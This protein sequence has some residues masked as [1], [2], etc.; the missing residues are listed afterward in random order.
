MV[1][2]KQL[3]EAQEDKIK[4]ACTKLW[5]DQQAGNIPNIWRITTYY[6]VPRS[7]LREVSCTDSNT[8]WLPSPAEGRSKIRRSVQPRHAW[9][10]MHAHSLHNGREHNTSWF[11]RAFCSPSSTKRL[12]VFNGL[13]SIIICYPDSQWGSS[14]SWIPQPFTPKD[15]LPGSHYLFIIHIILITTYLIHLT[16]IPTSKSRYLSHCR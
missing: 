11:T 15:N 3:R 10:E 13:A 1:K 2:P 9:T 8:P 12:K 7:T 5:E 16:V 4:K 14:E 6:G